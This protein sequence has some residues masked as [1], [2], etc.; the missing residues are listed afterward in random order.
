MNNEEKIINKTEETISD[1]EHVRKI[2]ELVRSLANHIND[3]IS[4]Y[5]DPFD[6]AWALSKVA[7]ICA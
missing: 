4:K 3:E 1:P 5:E 2:G 6:R 7:D